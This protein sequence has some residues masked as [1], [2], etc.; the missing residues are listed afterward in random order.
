MAQTVVP[1]FT[2]WTAADLIERFGPI[3]LHRIR[4]DPPPG[5]ATED[6]VGRIPDQAIADLVPDL[7]IEVISRSNTREEL[8]R[9][10]G[11]Y[12]SAG[13]HLVWYVYPQTREVHVFTAVNQTFVL[14]EHDA[15]N[16]GDVLPGLLLPISDL[17]AQPPG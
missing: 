3:P 7:A 5:T 6:D 9:K 4:H 8:E 16:G 2:N 17:F 12:F 1:T 13:V 14:G 15:M 10:L 11:E